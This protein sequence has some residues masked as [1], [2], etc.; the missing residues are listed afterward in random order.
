MS[1]NKVCNVQVFLNEFHFI[2]VMRRWADLALW[3][4]ERLRLLGAG[5][6]HLIG[7]GVISAFLTRKRR[8]WSEGFRVIL[9]ARAHA[10]RVKLE[11]LKRF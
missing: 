1:L 8:V 7:A 6:K 5:V 11:Q 2:I 3:E 10:G 4:R 9:L